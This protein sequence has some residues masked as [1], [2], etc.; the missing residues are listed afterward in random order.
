VECTLGVHTYNK[1]LFVIKF[2]CVLTNVFTKGRPTCARHVWA[3]LVCRN[4]AASCRRICRCIADL[5]LAQRSV[6][7]IVA[8]KNKTARETAATLMSPSLGSLKSFSTVLRWPR[9]SDFGGVMVWCLLFR[10]ADGFSP[11]CVPFLVFPWLL[12][13]F[14]KLFLI[15]F[16]CVFPYFLCTV[17]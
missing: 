7:M 5:E 3:C 15:K 2:L 10:V 17:A 4:A 13:T 1:K 8:T 11:C 16:E 9:F 12:P 6:S 14:K